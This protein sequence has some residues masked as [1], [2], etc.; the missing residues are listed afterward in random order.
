[1]RPCAEVPSVE[2]L[3]RLVSFPVRRNAGFMPSKIDPRVD[4]YIAKAAPFAQPILE[5]LRAVVHRA[6]P[7]AIETIKW[8]SPF[9]TYE[10][11]IL[12]HFAAFKAH[13]AFGYWH[14]EM[15]KVVGGS[16]SQAQQA[17]GHLGRIESLDDLPDDKTLT[18]HI[19]AAAKLIESGTPAFTRERK[20][21]PEAQVP[22]D[23]AAALK[24]SKAA[25]ITFNNFS[26]S[27]RR[28]YV[29]WITGA[30]REE[31]REARLQQAV[32]WMAE[33]KTRQWKYEKC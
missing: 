33:G 12:C 29:E 6:C 18:R 3:N 13:C 32:E 5:H 16:G 24:K 28:E 2:R 17:M 23:L 9:F 10:D 20:A 14:Q 11:A 15:E 25:T 26:P 21:K 27:C 22:P 1:M 30:K 4:A 31:T 7:R 19:Q 8:S